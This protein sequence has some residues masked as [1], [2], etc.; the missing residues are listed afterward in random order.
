MSHRYRVS[1]LATALGLGLMSAPVHAELS[2]SAALTSDYLFRGLSQ[3]N[4][5]PAV[6]AGFEFAGESG[7][8]LG[9]WGSNISWLSDLSATGSEISSSL[10]LDVYGGYRGQFSDSVSFDVGAIYYYYPGDFPGGFNSADTTEIYFGIGVG[11]FSAKYSYA[12]TDL[13][14]YGN[15]DG[16]GYLEVGGD[17]ELS[18]GWALSA[19]AGHQSIEGSGNGAFDYTDFK[20]GV[21]KAFEN[22]FDV[23]LAYVDTDAEAALYTN[24]F[25]N[26]IADATLTLTLTKSF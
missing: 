1:A 9:T 8:Y 10:E 22:G 18:D 2:G 19:H 6:Q 20:L 3:T 11:F 25:G 23:A 15:S 13:F 7:I 24:A 5:D 12:L 16:S 21:S 26:N 4:G 14:G 17:W